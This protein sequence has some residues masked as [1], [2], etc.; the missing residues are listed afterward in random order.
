MVE[1]HG[2]GSDW[3]ESGRSWSKRAAEEYILSWNLFTGTSR[4]W[5]S[6]YNAGFVGLQLEDNKAA[7]YSDL[8]ALVLARKR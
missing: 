7:V 3:L 1:V 2:G 6:S 8:I 4:A 5:K